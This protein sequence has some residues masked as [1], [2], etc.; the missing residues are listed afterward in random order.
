VDRS[1]S[2]GLDDFFSVALGRT[3]VQEAGATFGPFDNLEVRNTDLSRRDYRSGVV[4][5]RYRVTDRWIFNLNYTHQFR[6]HGNFE[7]EA[8]N[9]PGNYSIIGDYPEVFNS[10]ERY[11]PYGRLNDYQKHKVRAWTTFGVDLGRG[12]DVSLSALYRYDSPETFS[13]AASAVTPSTI[14]LARNPG[15]ARNLAATGA[16][17][18]FGG[19]GTGE[20]ESSHIFDFALNY[21]VP[22]WKRLRPWFKAEL[23]NAFHDQSLI[24]FNTTITAVRT[25]D[26]PV[27]ADGIP[28]TY[29]RG[30]SFGQPTNNARIAGAHLP[31]PREFRFSVGFRF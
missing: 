30:G 10:E 18:F 29:T 21:D 3:T 15:Y 13:F 31:N 22:V 14:Q 7:G 17:V 11:Y 12:G 20:F 9:Q 8:T 1:L 23:R 25:A 6:N 5:G 28:T 24:G 27:D 26:A 16:V 2:N 19:R 4:E